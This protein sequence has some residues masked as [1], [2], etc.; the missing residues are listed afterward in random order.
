MSLFGLASLPFELY[1]RKH[2]VFRASPVHKIRNMPNFPNAVFL[3]KRMG[4]PPWK[5]SLFVGFEFSRKRD[6]KC[7]LKFYI[8]KVVFLPTEWCQGCCASVD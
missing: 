2:H 7:Y 6:N 5:V 8:K 3:K 4:Y 1:L